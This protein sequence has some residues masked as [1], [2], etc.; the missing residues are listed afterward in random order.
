MSFSPP[1]GGKAANAAAQM[2]SGYR[3]PNRRGYGKKIV[4]VSILNCKFLKD[5]GIPH[6]PRIALIKTK[7]ESNQ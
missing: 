7:N 2:N 3:H 5:F 4:P 6:S 1:S